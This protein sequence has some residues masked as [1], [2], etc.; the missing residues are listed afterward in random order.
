M[1]T[2]VSVPL[3]VNGRIGTQSWMVRGNRLTHSFWH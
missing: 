3:S 1:Y 2:H